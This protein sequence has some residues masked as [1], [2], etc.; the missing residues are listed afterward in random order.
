MRFWHR[1]E[2]LISLIR[3]RLSRPLQSNNISTTDLGTTLATNLGKFDFA[4]LQERILNFVL[5][6]TITESFAVLSTPQKN[7]SKILPIDLID[8]SDIATI[9][10]NKKI[11]L[12]TE[13]LT[14]L[15]K[16]VEKR[17]FDAP[18]AESFVTKVFSKALENNLNIQ[19]DQNIDFA[20][21]LGES[22]LLLLVSF[23]LLM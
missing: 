19:E 22:L 2:R 20:K 21:V 1:S 17:S 23:S 9:S 3:L 4:I 6:K 16:F 14:D 11:S 5:L 13:I 7:L 10:P 18:E 12:D 8:I 15:I